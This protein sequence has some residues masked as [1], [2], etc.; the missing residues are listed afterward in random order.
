MVPVAEEVRG[1]AGGRRS[2]AGLKRFF[3]SGAVKREVQ[4]RANTLGT[5]GCRVRR[6]IGSARPHRGFLRVVREGMM[7]QP[8]R[9]VWCTA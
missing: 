2:G 5:F 7:V 6:S 8:Y 1:A 9:H 3:N 4:Q